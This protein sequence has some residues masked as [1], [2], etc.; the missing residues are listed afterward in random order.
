MASSV[1]GKDEPCKLRAVIGYPSGQDGAIL[2]SRD[3]PLRLVDYLQVENSG[4]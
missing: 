4:S 3:Y 2:P 1:S